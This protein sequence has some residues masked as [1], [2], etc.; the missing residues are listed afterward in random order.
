MQWR[1]FFLFHNYFTK[2]KTKQKTTNSFRNVHFQVDCRLKR[3]SSFDFYDIFS[4]YAMHSA[5]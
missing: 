3:Q 5:H 4:I 2:P 1:L